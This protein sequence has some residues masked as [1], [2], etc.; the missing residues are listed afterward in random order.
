[1]K[2]AMPEELVEEAVPVLEAHLPEEQVRRLIPVELTRV[3]P[4]AEA[5]P[6]LGALVRLRAGLLAVAVYGMETGTLSLR[7]PRVSV[8]AESLRSLL[9]EIPVPEG[10]VLWTNP[11]TEAPTPSLAGRTTS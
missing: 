7:L 9:K 4:L 2:R 11:E 5:E 1:M 10:A 8:S 6:S 3:D